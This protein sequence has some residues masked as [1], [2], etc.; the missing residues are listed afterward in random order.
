MR[1]NAMVK[2]TCN[3]CGTSEDIQPIRT[4]NE[5]YEKFQQSVTHIARVM[6]WYIGKIGHIDICPA[7][8]K[9]LVLQTY[10]YNKKEG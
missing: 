5:E 1:S 3:S 9:D 8:L 7:C 4:N 2:L 10:M 6:G